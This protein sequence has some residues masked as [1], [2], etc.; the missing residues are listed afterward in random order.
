MDTEL[1]K[2]NFNNSNSCSIVNSNSISIS[3]NDDRS[4]QRIDDDNITLKGLITNDRS[5][6]VWFW[7]SILMM[8]RTHML[9]QY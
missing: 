5:F 4:S 6:V 9:L 3:I 2:L 7:A 1:T 8:E